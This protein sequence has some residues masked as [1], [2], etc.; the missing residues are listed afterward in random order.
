MAARCAKLEDRFAT[1]AFSRRCASRVTKC[2]LFRIPG[3]KD[4]PRGAAVNERS[5]SHVAGPPICHGIL[6]D[7]LFG[8]RIL[9]LCHSPAFLFPAPV[10]GSSH[11]GVFTGVSKDPELNQRTP[12]P[13]ISDYLSFD[14]AV[15]RSSHMGDCHRHHSAI[16][17]SV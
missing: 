17:G 3:I 10:G 1:R 6:P 14:S 16:H 2:W 11:G 13:G 9:S 4:S 7:L 5:R 15:V 8:P 12:R